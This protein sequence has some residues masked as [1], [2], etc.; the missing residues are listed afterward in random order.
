MRNI[1]FIAFLAAVMLQAG[2]K[3][4]TVSPYNFSK[5]TV[6][7]N[8]CMYISEV[9]TTDWGYDAAWTTVEYNFINF[10]D[11]VIVTDSLAGYI[12][13]S[14]PCPNPSEGVFI[15]GLNT[16]RQCMMRLACVNTEM[17]IL[18]Y[19]VKKLTGGPIVTAYDFRSNTAFHK[20]EN[21]RIY[22][23]FY[24]SKDSLYY[25]GHGDFRIE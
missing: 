23:G 7:D 22:Y 6:A 3:K 4:S 13:V 2:C 9:D 12:Q 11:S 25:K 10:K 1:L 21:Y 15:M 19:T 5:I 18:Y 16:E 17:Q 14:A 24:N 8:S 20:N